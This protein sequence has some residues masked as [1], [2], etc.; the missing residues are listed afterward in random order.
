M[1]STHSL[2]MTSGPISKRLITFAFPVLVTFLLQQLYTV[3][4][5]AI[6]GRFAQNGMQALAAV[7]AVGPFVAL[8]LNMNSGLSAAVNV[9]CANL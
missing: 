4:D 6:V 2:D 8:V 1:A 9:R 5:K 3:A 7:G